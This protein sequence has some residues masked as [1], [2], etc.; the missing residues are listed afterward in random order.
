MSTGNLK[1]CVPARG[2]ARECVIGS[3]REKL[4]SDFLLS[5]RCFSCIFKLINSN[6]YF[7]AYRL[8]ASISYLSLLDYFYIDTFLHTYIPTLHTFDIYLF[9]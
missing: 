8:F 3:E 1:K 6:A 7:D 5:M 2:R 4:A 9:L